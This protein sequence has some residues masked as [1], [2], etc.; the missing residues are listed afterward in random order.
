M[1]KKAQV[2]QVEEDPEGQNA[3][4][5]VEKID[6]PAIFGEGK[7]NLVLD[8][9]REQVGT[10]VADVETNDGRATLRSVAYRITRSK[11]L[12]EEKGKA[13]ADDLTK[14]LGAINKNRRTLRDKLDALRDEVRQPL[15]DWEAA[16]KKRTDAIADRIN[17]LIGA[18][19]TAG[20]SSAD[21]AEVL[22]EVRGKE[23]SAELYGERMGEAAIAKDVATSNLERALKAAQKREAEAAE[24]E[25]LR[26]EKEA[27]DIEDR[28]R[29]AAESAA[30][31]ARLQAE[32]QAQARIDAAEKEAREAREAAE[33][34]QR[35]ADERE[36]LNAL[37][38]RQQELDDELRAKNLE[39]VGK[40]WQEAAEA[41][42]EWADL[43]SDQAA[44]V[45]TLIAHNRIPNILI[46]Y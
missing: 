12:V 33:K 16:E 38:A 34:V 8:Y 22:E 43:N 28:A 4:I 1:P 45:V 20:T 25:I 11:T 2:P 9:I 27:R 14:R 26:K 30:E 40:C 32:R 5:P 13:Y 6:A 46:K 36:R 39:H 35:D 31:T 23:L 3:L 10:V 42:M 19:Q 17:W 15:T 21:I 44:T 29:R 37:Q 41:L 7:V 18:G 24:L